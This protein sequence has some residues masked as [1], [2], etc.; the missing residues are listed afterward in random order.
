MNGHT[1]FIGDNNAGKSTILE[2]LDLVLGPD[3]LNRTPVIDE[4]DFYAGSYISE[5]TPKEIVIEVLITGLNPE[6]KRKF[7]N[8][9]EFWDTEKL[10][11]VDEPPAE[12]VDEPQITEAL[13]VCFRG[14]YDDDEDD[15]TGE[16]TYCHPEREDS[17][18]STFS[19]KDKRDCG[20]LYLRALRTGSRALSLER[21]SLLDII[22]KIRELRPKMWE[23]ILIKLRSTTVADDPSIGVQEV[24]E[25]VQKSLKDFVPADWGSE[26]HLKVTDLTRENLRK[27]LNVFMSTGSDDYFA[28]FHHQGTGTVNTMVLALLSMIAEMKDTV[29]FAM[30]E[31]E[32]AIPPY[33]QKRIVNIIRKKAN[34]AI[35][36]SHSP[37]VLEEF[38]PE[39]ICLINRTKGKVFSN[40]VTLP[41]H[42]KPKMY[43]SEF[44]LRFA[45][46]LLAKRVLIA[47]GSTEATAYSAVAKRA[48]E[49]K[50]DKY[51]SLE[52]LGVAIFDAGTETM[53]ATYGAYF[54]TLK[55]QVFAVFDKQTDDNIEKIKE[56]VNH[57]YEIPY[58][59]FEKLI[60]EEVAGEA[61]RRFLLSI[62]ENEEWP[63][64]LKDIE[65]SEDSSD[66][67]IDTAL[68]KYLKG[69]KGAASAAD[70][71]GQCGIKELPLSLRQT[72]H[73]IKEKVTI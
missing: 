40:S 7:K 51:S 14:K 49:L 20:F 9:I 73:D 41:A 70:L 28:P 31:P 18:F 13:R 22:L 17:A 35:F 15:F 38:A 50:P 1:V 47:E 11:I 65:P 52:A 71:L 21:G 2:A 53:I 58:K 8:H 69:A 62:V 39:R 57:H 54:K 43:R 10:Q 56:N 34:Q 72:I 30:E 19:K 48:E 29:I 5:S 12:T 64:H 61:K 55:K 45:E 27:T 33:T 4:H 68:M 36:T 24:L 46:A 67:D 44:R 60:I 26:P 23:D 16:T 6:Q 63:R 42:I 25:G 59:G 3:R 32:I 37:F 66:E